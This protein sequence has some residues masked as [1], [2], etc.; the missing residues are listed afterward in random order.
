MLNKKIFSVIIMMMFLAGCAAPGPMHTI[1]GPMNTPVFDPV[2]L[3]TVKDGSKKVRFKE[4]TTMYENKELQLWGVFFITDNGAYLANWDM[5]GYEYNLRYK[6]AASE[7]DSISD[8]KVVRSMWADSNLLIIKDK[9]GHEVGF[10][11]NGKNAARAI[12]REISE[13]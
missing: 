7:L 4:W 2:I 11:L 1:R 8:D 12:L 5:N 6:L 3:D 9:N 13:K 10:A